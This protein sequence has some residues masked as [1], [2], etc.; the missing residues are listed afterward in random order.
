MS[1][2]IALPL[3]EDTLESNRDGAEKRILGYSSL[4]EEG[5]SV[6]SA[7]DRDHDIRPVYVVGYDDGDVFMVTSGVL[8]GRV[9]GFEILYF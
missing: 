2:G 9:V 8:F 3:E 1:L 5:D 4:G 7:S 6:T